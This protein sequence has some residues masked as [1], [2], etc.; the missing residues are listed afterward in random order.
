MSFV[1]VSS[2]WYSYHLCRCTMC[3]KWYMHHINDTNNTWSV[4]CISVHH[5]YVAHHTGWPRLIGS[6]KLQIIF[7]KRATKCRSLLR[8]TT[9]KDKGSYESS[10]PCMRHSYV[11]ICIIR[12]CVSF[13]YT[14]T[15][16]YIC[17]YTHI[18][19]CIS[20]TCVSFVCCWSHMSFMW[21][22]Y[23]VC[24]YHLCDTHII[25]ACTHFIGL[26]LFQLYPCSNVHW[27]RFF[28]FY[29][30]LHVTL[31]LA[32]PPQQ[33]FS[34]LRGLSEIEGTLGSRNYVDLDWRFMQEA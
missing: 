9:H 19:I 4:P 12:M 18:I 34:H 28:C 6:P 23:N 22:T 32:S 7:H 29:S 15:Y 2:M 8:K 26:F 31:H 14:Y 17:T 3:H 25:C 30:F 24:V 20:R 13:V 27:V 33:P 21:H 1:C 10:P 16:I 5:L 11:I